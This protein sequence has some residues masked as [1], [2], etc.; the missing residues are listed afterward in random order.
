MF[1]FVLANL[2]HTLGAAGSAVVS[3]LF[4]VLAIYSLYVLWTGTA[5]AT[6]KLLWTIAIFFLPFLGSILYLLLGRK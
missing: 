6:G 3:L 5:S 2:F 4:A 1:S